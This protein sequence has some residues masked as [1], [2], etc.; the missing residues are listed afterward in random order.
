MGNNV[1]SLTE[2]NLTD[3][4]K[5]YEFI[6]KVPQ[7]IREGKTISTSP[8]K[9]FTQNDNSNLSIGERVAKYSEQ[10]R[11]KVLSVENFLQ[12]WGR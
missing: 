8:T 9:L 11:N 5:A 6:N 2:K 3:I 4:S 1:E 7:L 10:Q 12:E